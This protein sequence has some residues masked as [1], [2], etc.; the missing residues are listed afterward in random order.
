M[1]YITYDSRM[2]GQP[3]PL[4][5]QGLPVPTGSDA[6]QNNRIVPD[7]TAIRTA[8]QAMGDDPKYDIL[9]LAE[10]TGLSVEKVQDYWTWLGIPI[11]HLDGP[12]FTDFDVEA[13]SDLNKIVQSE[14]LEDATIASLVRSVGHNAARMAY[15]QF[16]SLVENTTQRLKIDDAA[17]RRIVV[18]RF[19]QIAK[20]MDK[21]AKHAYLVAATRV[22]Q[23]NSEP[24]LV[25]TRPKRNNDNLP[26]PRVVGF[27]DIVG[28]TKRTASM[29]PG[30]L[31]AYIRDYEARTRDIV[32]GG[33]GRVVKMIG[34]AVLFLA[35]S[36]ES[37]VTIAL[38]LAEPKSNANAETPM[39]VGMVWGQ[40]V[41]RFGDVFGSRVNLA[42]R[43]TDIA[44]PNTLYV[45]P[46]TAALLVG[47][48]EYQLSVMPEAQIQ[49]LGSMRPV[50]VS[51]ISPPD[52]VDE[53]IIS[54]G[55]PIAENTLPNAAPT[56]AQ[57]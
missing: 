7:M 47:H 2:I 16:E 9:E 23:E 38:A 32:I 29:E 46:S 39:R 30:R 20:E 40:V 48:K 42:A 11:K 33:G 8:M 28:F 14:Q 13:L 45:D 10:R 34:D 12:L 24:E 44:A 31:T 21:Q 51:S 43:L 18:Q 22:I 35:D 3:E 17:A 25:P 5:P 54:T 57:S 1:K 19:P 50:K 53:A 55:A 49:G 6:A 27:A 37:G 26:A 56:A 52:A 15:W 4:G 36:L 41:Q